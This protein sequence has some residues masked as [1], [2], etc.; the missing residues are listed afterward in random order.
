[1][2]R[3]LVSIVVAVNLS[4]TASAQEGSTD[5]GE[6]CSVLRAR[7]E[8]VSWAA[9]Q[10][11]PL[12]CVPMS[13]RVNNVYPVGRQLKV[14][15][16]SCKTDIFYDKQGHPGLVCSPVIVI[17]KWE[18]NRPCQESDGPQMPAAWGRKF[19]RGAGTGL[20]HC[21]DGRI[22]IDIDAQEYCH[23]TLSEHSQ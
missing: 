21:D 14:K 3:L 8:G 6:S 1:M 4:A 20:T 22:A 7:N 5:S 16:L 18:L 19:C 2:K 15:G 17:A 23:I 10:A 11:L 13:D 12:R 9:Y